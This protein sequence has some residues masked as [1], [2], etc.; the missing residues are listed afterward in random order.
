MSFPQKYPLK[1]LHIISSTTFKLLVNEKTYLYYDNNF[2]WCG[3]T[4]NYENFTIIT[5]KL[6]FIEDA[7]KYLNTNYIAIEQ[8]DVFDSDDFKVIDF[9]PDFHFEGFNPIIGTNNI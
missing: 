7:K 8:H 6:T 2:K 4:T 9:T 3:T 5:G 1:T